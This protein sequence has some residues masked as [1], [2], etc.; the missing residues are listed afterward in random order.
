MIRN[1]VNIYLSA[2][3]NINSGNP[4]LR[5]DGITRITTFTLAQTGLAL[6]STILGEAILASFDLGS[7]EE[8]QEI[9]DLRNVVAPWSKNSSINVISMGNNK[10][11][12]MDMSAKQ[13]LCFCK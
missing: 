1:S 9:K 12:Y 5:E 3:D 4:K 11:S 10:L 13:S 7:E 6:G 2:I 8:E